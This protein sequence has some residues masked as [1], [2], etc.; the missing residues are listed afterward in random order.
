MIKHIKN[1][2]NIAH[3]KMKYHMITQITHN[4]SQNDIKQRIL[5]IKYVSHK[6]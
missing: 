6:M 2:I 3:I 4:I 5:V 1:E